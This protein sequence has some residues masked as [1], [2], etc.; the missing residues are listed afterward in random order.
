MRQSRTQ[1]D[2]RHVVASH[3][4]AVVLVVVILVSAR[5]VADDNQTLD[6]FLGRLGLSELRLLHRE[7][8]LAQEPATD[9]RAALAR[10]LADSYAEELIAAADEPNRFAKL[11]DR[12]E[13]LLT[14]YPD[15]RTPAVS[16]A[17][18]QA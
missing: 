8:M 16:V 13:K 7:R 18:L 3:G 2:P 17:L 11:K 14:A 4:H 5:I 9:K 6:Q 15:A 1:N 10:A 12:A